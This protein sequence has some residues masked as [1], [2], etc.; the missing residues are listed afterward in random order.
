VTNDPNR[1][2]Q[3]NNS[4]L[5]KPSD[6]SECCPKTTMPNSVENCAPN[7]SDSGS[8]NLPTFTRQLT[9]VGAPQTVF[10]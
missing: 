7:N 10:V 6:I 9:S 2:R 5:K 4:P 1:A 3:K 8:N